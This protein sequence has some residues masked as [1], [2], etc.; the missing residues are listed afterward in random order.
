LDYGATKI[1]LLPGIIDTKIKQM[2]T[3]L[4]FLWS[5][6]VETIQEKNELDYQCDNN[7]EQQKK[8][9][10][11]FCGYSGTADDLNCH[12]LNDHKK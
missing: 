1:R 4:K 8:S 6:L 9:W 5:S 3:F 2:K 7:N 11:P 10:C 12:L